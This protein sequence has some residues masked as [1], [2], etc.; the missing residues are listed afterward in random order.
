VKAFEFDHPWN[1]AGG[2]LQLVSRP[3]IGSGSHRSGWPCVVD[4][5]RQFETGTGLLLDDFTEATLY[6]KS[7]TKTCHSPWVGI[8]HHPVNVFS[9]LPGEQ[10]TLLRRQFS[11]RA[12]RRDAIRQLRGA[13]ALSSEGVRELRNCLKIPVL[14]IL[15]PTE[16]EVI[17][18]QPQSLASPRRIVQ[19]GYF[20]RNTRVIYQI[21][22]PGWKRVR[23]CHGRKRQHR[24]DLALRAN[25][26][27]AEF[28]LPAVESRTYVGNTEY[29]E[30]LSTS[31]VIT[32]MFGAAA[33]NVV[34][35]CIARGTPLLVNRLPAI[36]EYLGREYPLFFEDV[37]DVGKL[38]NDKLLLETH[39]Y[40]RERAAIIP[41]FH[42]FAQAIAQFV[43][44]LES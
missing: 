2:C 17:H 13:V 15:H 1:V 44:S 9:P 26:P 27:R 39:H 22:A 28:Y 18:W 21:D 24:R 16:H 38:L 36:E 32:E 31:V 43:Q 14:E 8:F 7:K 11:G 37:R 19:A 6:I 42:S 34:V 41:T 30:L 33:N 20:L 23:L 12:R 4:A 40:L 3:A 5:L 35:E 25:L 10:A 29:D